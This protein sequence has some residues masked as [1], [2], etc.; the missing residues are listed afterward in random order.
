MFS[1]VGNMNMMNY[2][3]WILEQT[4]LNILAEFSS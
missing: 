3:L 1:Y 4:L 2:A